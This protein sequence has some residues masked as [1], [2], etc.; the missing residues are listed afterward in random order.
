[1]GLIINPIP[2]ALTENQWLKISCTGLYPT[3]RVQEMFSHSSQ[4]YPALP[5]MAAG[6]TI[7]ELLGFHLGA[8]GTERKL[9][10]TSSVAWSKHSGGNHCPNK[11]RKE[12]MIPQLWMQQTVLD[13]CVC[14]QGLWMQYKCSFGCNLT[15]LNVCVCAEFYLYFFVRAKWSTGLV[16]ARSFNVPKPVNSI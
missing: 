12:E 11:G 9:G 15:V 6:K 3:P 10:S 5:M 14:V 1:M 4:H 13:M 8:Q 7:S 16:F 2:N